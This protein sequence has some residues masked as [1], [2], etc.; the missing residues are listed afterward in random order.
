[1]EVYGLRSEA[2]DRHAM[3]E[4]IMDKPAPC[5]L[6]SDNAKTETGRVWNDLMR[7]YAL[8]QTIP[9]PYYPWQDSVKKSIQDI[10]KDAETMLNRTGADPRSLF[11]AIDSAVFVSKMLV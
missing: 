9:E 6:H 8:R 4:F 2:Q 10:K 5:C 7:K 3:E 1:M 11:K